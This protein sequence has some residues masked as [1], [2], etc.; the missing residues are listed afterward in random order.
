MR[1]EPIS[2]HLNDKVFLKNHARWRNESLPWLRETK[3]TD[4]IAQHVYFSNL[5]HDKE[6]FVI[7]CDGEI[8]G[9]CGLTDIT[10]A[11]KTAEFSMLIGSEH[12]RKGYATLALKELL[13]Y[14][15]N[16][17][18]LELIFGETYRY[19]EKYGVNPA[20]KA[21]DRLGFTLEASLRNRYI[22]EGIHVDALVYSITKDEFRQKHPS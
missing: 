9:V 6:F 17:L 22:K 11:H 5:A 12:Q 4:W 2:K 13:Y 15:L 7:I 16:T 1:I 20:A 21:Y 3:K 19:H 18:G 14:G 10:F 8:K